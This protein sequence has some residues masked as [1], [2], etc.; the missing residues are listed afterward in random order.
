MSLL[1]MTTS[2]QLFLY[3]F[4]KKLFFL[5]HPN[6]I[7]FF[8]ITFQQTYINKINFDYNQL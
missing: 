7:N 5:L 1:G 6:E 8:Q 2:F 3:S 4:R